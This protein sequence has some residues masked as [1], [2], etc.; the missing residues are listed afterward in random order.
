MLKADLVEIVPEEQP[1]SYMAKMEEPQ[2]PPPQPRES[3]DSDKNSYSEKQPVNNNKIS[4]K[5]IKNGEIEIQVG[6]IRKAHEQVTEI[7]K[8]NNAYIRTEQFNNDD[9]SE[10]QFFTIRVSA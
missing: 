10:K 3:M 5:I 8:K 1:T 2:T 6:D 7:V 4:K 9:T